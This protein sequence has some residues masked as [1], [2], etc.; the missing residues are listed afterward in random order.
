MS[1]FVPEDMIS[2]EVEAGT[3]S[4]LHEDA[5]EIGT[6]MRGAFFTTNAP[7]SQKSDRLIDFFILDPNYKVI[8]SNR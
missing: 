6:F 7:G 4:T 8:H 3:E 2:I 1:D 5:P